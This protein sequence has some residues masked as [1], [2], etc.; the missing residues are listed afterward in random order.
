MRVMSFFSVLFYLVAGVG[1]IFFITNAKSI[2]RRTKLF[3]LNGSYLSAL[4][5]VVLTRLDQGVFSFMSLV[6]LFSLMSGYL[7]SIYGLSMRK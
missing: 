7:A 3:V 6:T 5:G 4:V 1:I 2:T